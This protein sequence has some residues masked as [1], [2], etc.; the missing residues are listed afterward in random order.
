MPCCS[1][2]LIAYYSCILLIIL[3][4]YHYSLL[5]YH[6]LVLLPQLNMKES[7]Q[8]VLLEIQNYSESLKS[9]PL[10]VIG[11]QLLRPLL[12]PTVTCQPV[13]QSLSFAVRR[14][15]VIL[16]LQGF[17]IHGLSCDV[18]I[19]TPIFSVNW[20]VLEIRYPTWQSCN[21]EHPPRE[22]FVSAFSSDN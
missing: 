6:D 10:Q 16:C 19:G 3:N 15:F 5:M 4:I 12:Y 8:I 14:I 18:V 11:A 21:Y 2:D 1:I 9:T 22:G 20:G 13:S 7:M 17:D